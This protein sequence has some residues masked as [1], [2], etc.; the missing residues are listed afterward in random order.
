MKYSK[1]LPVPIFIAIAAFMAF[2]LLFGDRLNNPIPLSARI[3][4]LLMVGVITFGFFYSR[5]RRG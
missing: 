3:F 2:G 1:P 5:R 4:G